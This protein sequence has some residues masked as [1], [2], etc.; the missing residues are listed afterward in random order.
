MDW[1]QDSD[2]LWAVCGILRGS[3]CEHSADF[4]SPD[5]AKSLCD[6]LV[7]L[8]DGQNGNC[9]WN[10][11]Q[12]KIMRKFDSTAILSKRITEREIMT[13]SFPSSFSIL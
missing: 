4:I 3:R 12:I 13:I 6:W 7:K 1:K 10:K 9:A 5:L 8:Y 11:S 2:K